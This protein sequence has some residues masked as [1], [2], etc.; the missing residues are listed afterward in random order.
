MGAAMRYRTLSGKHRLFTVLALFCAGAAPSPCVASTGLTGRVY[1][2][3]DKGY[4]NV[5]M[6]A[7]NTSAGRNGPGS[8]NTIFSSVLPSVIVLAECAQDV[9]NAVRWARS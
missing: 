4:E 5:R 9:V 6:A 7:L 8:V 1:Y 3:G 2:R